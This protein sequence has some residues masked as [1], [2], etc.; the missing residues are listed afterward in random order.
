MK[1]FYIKNAKN[2]NSGIDL[3]FLIYILGITIYQVA[4]YPEIGTLI[5]AHS[6]SAELWTISGYFIAGLSFSSLV[7]RLG[8]ILRNRG[9]I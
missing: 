6:L 9:I 7:D 1:N 5:P 2:I 3:L 4:H 8:E